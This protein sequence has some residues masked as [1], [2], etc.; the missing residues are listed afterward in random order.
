MQR[1]YPIF[2]DVY[3][4]GDALYRLSN[5]PWTA[6]LACSKQSVNQLW[7]MGTMMD[8]IHL[9]PADSIFPKIPCCRCGDLTRWWDRIA[10]KTYCPNCLEALAM[11]EGDPLIAKVDRK[12]C[13]VC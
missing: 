10:G 7:S 8:S 5:S 3:P 6:P 1:N 12:R 2:V 11:G 13:A 4:V 9:A